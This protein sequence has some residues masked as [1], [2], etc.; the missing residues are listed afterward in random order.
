MFIYLLGVLSTI[1]LILFF[2]RR[3][4]SNHYMSTKI[5]EMP[6]ILLS[7][8][9]FSI[10]MISFLFTKRRIIDFIDCITDWIEGKDKDV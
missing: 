10:I 4:G 9:A 3:Y 5:G 2:N 6:V 1:I 8:I 7:W